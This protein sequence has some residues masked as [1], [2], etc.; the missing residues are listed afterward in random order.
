MH[1][2]VLRFARTI[3]PFIAPGRDILEVGSQD[4]N[5]SVRPIFLAFSPA[6]YLGVDAAAGKGV[7]RVVPAESLESEFHEASFSLVISTETLEHVQPIWRI[8]SGMKR[9][10]RPGGYLFVTTRSPGFPYHGYPDDFWRFT[11][12]TMASLFG[13]MDVVIL[14]EDPEFPGVFMVA[15]K[16]HEFRLKEFSILDVFNNV[17]VVTRPEVVADAKTQA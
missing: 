12:A 15:K 14:E 13:D 4:V 10:L 3:A 6:S 9:V 8:V 17:P 7:D 16:P 1:S 11:T 5:G 2:S